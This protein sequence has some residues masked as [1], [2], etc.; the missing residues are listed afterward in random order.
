MAPDQINRIEASQMK[1]NRIA[2]IGGGTAGWLAANHLGYELRS[3]PD[4]EITLIESE[5]VPIIGVGE[6]TVPLIANSLEKFGISEADF[7]VSCDTT[8]KHGIKFVGWLNSSIHGKGHYYYH[9]F[10][11]AFP[12]GYDLTPYMLSNRSRLNFSE[13]NVGLEICEAMKCPKKV[14]SLPFKG[15]IGYAY[16]VNAH[17]FASAL[18]RNAKEKYSITHKLATVVDATR[19][20]D[21]SI[22]EL[23]LKNGEKIGFDFYIDCS[24]SA[25]LLGGKVLNI[26]FVDKSNHILTDTAL[27]QQLPYKENEEIPPFTKATAHEAGWIW[28]IPVI[29]RRGTGFVYSS[30]HMSDDVAATE[31]AKYLGIEEKDFSPRKISFNTGY[32]KEFWSSNCISLGLAQGFVEPLEATS[33]LLTDLSAELFAKNF[34]KLK[35]D[36]DVLKGHCN[37]VVEYWWERTIDF[38]QVHYQASDRNDSEF[39]SDNVNSKHV[40][41]ILQER[42]SRWKLVSPKKS[43]FFS[44]FDLFDASSYSYVLYGMK[45]NTRQPPLSEAQRNESADHLKMIKE[46]S[47]RLTRELLTHRDW[48]MKL[49]EVMKLEAA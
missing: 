18:A 37:K 27:V 7:I 8:F 47:E 20:N 26:P 24:G 9:P 44:H 4:I 16:H 43:D 22:D 3:D 36:I 23:V 32:R 21:G 40:S 35:S 45:F 5:D 31:Y 1:I 15:V 28:D 6:G 12:D 17:K 33:I 48:L 42:L 38:I 39:W 11:S 13:L 30:A 19:N 46:G 29:N 49:R 34:P 10:S 41:D 14:S 2:I 25:A